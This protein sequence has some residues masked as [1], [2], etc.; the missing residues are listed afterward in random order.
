MLN[1]LY[2]LVFDCDEYLTTVTGVNF[3]SVLTPIACGI[4]MSLIILKFLKKAFD[5]YV[6]WTDGD[7]D[8]DPM[9]LLTNF[10][11]AIA[12][13]LI[14]L[15]LYEIFVNVCRDITD[16]ILTV[17]NDNCE[18]TNAWVT[19]ITS[20]GIV[21]AIAG[22]IFVI[23]FLILYFSFMMSF[24]LQWSALRA[25]SVLHHLQRTLLH[26]LAAEPPKQWLYALT[27]RA[28]RSLI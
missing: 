9:L 14:F 11:R 20:M 2:K 24:I 18:F 27:T 4:G 21:P 25:V 22:L 28:Y 7:P 16:T 8:A 6:L 10:V 26:I 17:I 19:A 13:S 3:F 23:C 1:E 5:I 12:T 15:W